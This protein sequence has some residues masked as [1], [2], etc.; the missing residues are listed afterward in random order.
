MK[1]LPILLIFGLSLY[2]SPLKAQD[3]GATI[4]EQFVDVIEKSNR[5]EDYK[6]VK[7]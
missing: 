6:V 5:Y 7:I 4:D 1:S 2:I 3:R